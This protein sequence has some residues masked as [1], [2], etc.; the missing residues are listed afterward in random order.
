MN[1]EMRSYSKLTQKNKT[2]AKKV[3]LTKNTLYIHTYSHGYKTQTAIVNTQTNLIFF[4]F[5]F[6]NF[7]IKLTLTGAQ[8]FV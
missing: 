3:F 6:Y 8:L 2:R 5:S 7:L 4:I 1:N